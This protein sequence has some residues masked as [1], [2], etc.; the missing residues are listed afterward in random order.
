[1]G[2]APLGP[3]GP[4][5]PPGNNG[6]PGDAGLIGP[7]GPIGLQGLPGK[8]GPR[9]IP[10]PQGEPGP[11]GQRSQALFLPPTVQAGFKPPYVN[12][13]LKRESVWNTQSPDYEG[14]DEELVE[15]EQ[16]RFNSTHWP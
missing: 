1:M 5:G 15:D 6:V 10:G 14:Y 7:I 2:S 9:G 3:P 11:R 13:Q 16:V 8:T 4:R 12:K